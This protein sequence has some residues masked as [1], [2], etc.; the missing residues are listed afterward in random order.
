[1]SAADFVFKRLE[2]AIQIPEKKKERMTG[3]AVLFISQ[4]RSQT[5]NDSKPP[6]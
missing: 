4:Q 2:N 3:V 6:H 5:V 1:M